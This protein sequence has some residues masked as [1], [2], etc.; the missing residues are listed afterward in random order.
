MLE[1]QRCPRDLSVF[2]RLTLDPSG[3]EELTTAGVSLYSG[4]A[5]RSLAP[6]AAVITYELPHPDAPTS[7]REAATALAQVEATCAGAQISIR[8][9]NEGML[10]TADNAPLFAIR[11]KRLFAPP[12]AL[13][14]E[15][16]LVLEAANRAT[17][18][19]TPEAVM[20]DQLGTYD[21]LF[22]F[23]HRG[24]T[25]L[26]RCEGHPYMDILAGRIAREIEGIFV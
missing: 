13:C 6:E 14:I 5:L 1:T 18:K 22:Y 19:V 7:V 23:D 16:Q 15:S 3:K 26:S 25:A 9:D 24:A 17:L 11:G 10:R 2:V 12:A 21:E 20:R 4:Y 8:C